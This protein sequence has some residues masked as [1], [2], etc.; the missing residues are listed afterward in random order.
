MRGRE[1][2]SKKEGICVYIELIHLIIQQKHNIVKQ[3]YSTNE[4][5]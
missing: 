1:K 5:T 3:L 2:D 4:K